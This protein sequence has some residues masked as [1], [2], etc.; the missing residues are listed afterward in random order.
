MAKITDVE[1]FNDAIFPESVTFLC[2][3]LTPTIRK[4]SL[5][6]QF[7][8]KDENVQALVTRCD[9]INELNICSIFAS[10]TNKAI[11]YIVKNLSNTLVKLGIGYETEAILQ[12][13]QLMEK[14]RYSIPCP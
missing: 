5:F 13:L 3:N 9:K 10:I 14:L 12:E 11:T 7:W 2:N 1:D 4:L 6:N 8:L